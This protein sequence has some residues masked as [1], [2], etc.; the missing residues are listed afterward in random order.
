M[1]GTRKRGKPLTTRRSEAEEELNTM[2]V[3]NKQAMVT[4]FWKCRKI[5]VEAKVRKDRNA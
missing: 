3:K 2:R 4:D 5:V 1:E